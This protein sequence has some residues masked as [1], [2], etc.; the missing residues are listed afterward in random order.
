MEGPYATPE[1][2]RRNVPHRHKPL[3]HPPAQALREDHALEALENYRRRKEL[4]TLY[5]RLLAFQVS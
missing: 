1:N 5:G 3:F 2:F 4:E